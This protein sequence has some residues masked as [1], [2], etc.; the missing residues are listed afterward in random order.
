M[1]FSDILRVVLEAHSQLALS[2]TFL[3]MGELIR[4]N[5]KVI[6]GKVSPLQ[7]KI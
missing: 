6:F 5:D 3:L 2:N 7:I 4:G 1:E